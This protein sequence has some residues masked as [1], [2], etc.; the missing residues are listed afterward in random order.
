MIKQEITVTSDTNDIRVS[1]KVSQELRQW[2]AQLMQRLR[3]QPGKPKYPIRWTSER[4]RRFVMAK[5]RRENNLPYRR[6]GALVNA[7]DVSVNVQQVSRVE[8]WRAEVLIFL[9][10]LGVG[11]LPTTPPA[12]VI[13]EVSNP[14]DVEQYVTGVNQ[15]G[16]HQDTGWY[17]SPTIIDNAFVEVEGI[18]TNL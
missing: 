12:S 3:Q 2:Q 10:K 4:Q 7:W 6:T 9:A 5:L 8:A 17:Y 18:L 15:Q 16:F 11:S 14:S 1:R 13:I